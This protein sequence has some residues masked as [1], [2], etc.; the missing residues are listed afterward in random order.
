MTHCE[1]ILDFF[2]KNG[3]KATLG[4]LLEDGRFSYAHRITARFSDLRKKGYEIKCEKGKTPSQNLYILTSMSAN[5]PVD[6]YKFE[7]NE[8][9]FNFAEI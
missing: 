3:G 6:M 8:G 9:R 4:E 1:M 5:K 2:G 7:G